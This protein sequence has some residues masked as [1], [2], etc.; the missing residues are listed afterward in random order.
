MHLYV[1]QMHYNVATLVGAHAWSSTD[2][3]WL[4]AYQ[5][6]KWAAKLVDPQCIFAAIGP[7]A[8]CFE[9]LPEGKI[10][11]AFRVSKS[12][13]AVGFTGGT[14]SNPTFKPFPNS[15]GNY[16]VENLQDVH[17]YHYGSF[18]STEYFVNWYGYD[19]TKSIWVFVSNP[20]DFAEIFPSFKE[21]KGLYLAHKRVLY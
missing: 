8:F 16:E 13:P 10:N 6:H 20:N 14:S 1:N 9:L 4:P 5:S 19:L 15:S 3:L 18:F 2:H 21:F 17:V 7:A 12:K 11:N